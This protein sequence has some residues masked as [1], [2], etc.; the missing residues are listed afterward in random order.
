MKDRDLG[1]QT[2]PRRRFL[3]LG[4]GFAGLIASG[5]P[6]PARV[7]AKVESTEMGPELEDS[8]EDFNDDS[9]S[10]EPMVADSLVVSEDQGEDL[11][12]IGLNQSVKKAQIRI[13][14]EQWR[15]NPALKNRISGPNNA[16]RYN[17]GDLTRPWHKQ[18]F[19][20]IDS[21]RQNRFLMGTSDETR[22]GSVLFNNTDPNK[23]PG[24]VVEF[25]GRCDAQNKM[26]ITVE[27]MDGGQ[28]RRILA[29]CDFLIRY[30]RR[31]FVPT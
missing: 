14:A 21:Q 10:I 23:P 9:I 29:P 24:E 1:R 17:P 3:Q 5:V 4:L 15:R 12:R 30:T 2:L 27:R 20:V 18:K 13:R 26:P 31:M 25:R 8:G 19:K 11:L 16:P 7:E 6:S 28:V 22:D